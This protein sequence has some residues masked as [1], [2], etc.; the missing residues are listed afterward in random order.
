[1]CSPTV[2]ADNSAAEAR[3]EEG[4]RT[5]AIGQGRDNINKAFSGFNDDF[6]NGV[7]NDY[8][9]SLK[10]QLTTDYNSA[11]RQLSLQLA[12]S[13]NLESSSAARKFGQLYQ[14]QAD[15]LADIQNRALDQA[16][17][18][19]ASVDAA[20]RNLIAD[21]AVAADPS[22]AAAAAKTAAEGIGAPHTTPAL[23]DVFGDILQGT[24]LASALNNYQT[25]QAA[26]DTP[27]LFPRGNATGRI[28]GGKT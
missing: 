3:A 18:V 5:V 7:A 24:A 25:Q 2:R 14:R 13:G 26:N 22:Q 9:N 16:S 10:P 27:L 21:N 4:R 28:I 23:G 15:T 12:T 19:R 6:Y 11:Y 8:T 1:M 20:K 17:S